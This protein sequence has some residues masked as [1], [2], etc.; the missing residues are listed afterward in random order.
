MANAEIHTRRVLCPCPQEKPHHA[1]VGHF[2]SFRKFIFFLGTKNSGQESW[3]WVLLEH[4]LYGAFK[5]QLKYWSCVTIS[6]YMFIITAPMQGDRCQVWREWRG[7]LWG[8][9]VMTG[10][11]SCREARKYKRN[12]LFIESCCSSCYTA[13]TKA[14]AESVSLK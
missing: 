14:A 11:N 5:M 4:F 2:S 10:A 6:Q 1:I 3:T 9:M 7:K 12:S 8:T 13:C